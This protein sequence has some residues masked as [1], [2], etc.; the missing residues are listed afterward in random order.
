M[1]TA[2]H[3]LYISGPH[4]LLL[5]PPLMFVVATLSYYLVER[6]SVQLGKRLVAWRG[7]LVEKRRHDASSQMALIPKELDNRSGLG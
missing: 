4:S 1:F 2:P 6:P 7:G 3:W 5:I